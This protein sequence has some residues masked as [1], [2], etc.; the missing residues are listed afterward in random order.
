MRECCGVFGV[1]DY[2]GKNAVFNIY[3]GLMTLHHR[4]QESAGISLYEKSGI[5]TGKVYGLVNEKLLTNMKKYKSAVGIGH[6]RYSTAGNSTLYNAQPICNRSMSIAHNG[7]LVNNIQL[8]SQLT[9][10]GSKLKTKSDSEL[11]LTLL[12]KERASTGDL[13]E[14]I[15]NS[16]NKLE[17]AFS[18]VLLTNDGKVVAIR[19]P[20]G[21]RPLC[22][23]EAEDIIAFS[24]ESIALDINSID[25]S[26][27][28]QPGEM[29]IADENGVQR[30]RYVSYTRRAH[31]MFEYVYFSRADSIIDGRS[32]YRV[33][34]K[35]G[36]NLARTYKTD[37]DVIIPVPDTSRTAAEGLSHESGIPV[38]EGLI[39]NRYVQRTFIMPEQKQRDGAVKIKLN[40]LKTVL[41]DKRV[42]LI[43]DSIVRGTTLKNIVHMIRKAGAREV[44]VRITCPPIISPCFY[45]IDIA[46]H[47]ELIA[48]YKKVEEIRKSIKSDTLG[49]QKISGLI[50][51]IGMPRE[52]LCLGCLMDQYPTSKAQELSDRLKNKNRKKRV[53]YWEDD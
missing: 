12:T 41:S 43:D 6:V 4:G 10:A 33:R 51:A 17:G 11:I 26:R 49:Y 47:D 14:A 36:V 52:D 3:L 7:N 42:L 22:E 37:V 25:L 50:D 15:R 35:L 24:S 28:I 19:D 16:A 40:P 8:R 30:K 31:C 34:Y 44:H 20:Y 13:F 32:V 5:K 21:F 9:K 45:G 38:A 53:R 2:K 29:V 18:L 1:Y 46:T 39:K 48:A 27:D 23:G